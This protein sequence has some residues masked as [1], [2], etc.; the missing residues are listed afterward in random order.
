LGIIVGFKGVGDL[1]EIPDV[2]AGS[3]LNLLYGLLVFCLIDTKSIII[4]E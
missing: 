4:S 3:T 1:N 2:I